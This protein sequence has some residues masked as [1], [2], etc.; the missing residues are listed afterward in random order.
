[1]GTKPILFMRLHPE[2]ASLLKAPCSNTLGLG[3]QC[4]DFGGT[5]TFSGVLKR[6]VEKAIRGREECLLIKQCGSS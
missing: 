6:F 5:Q 3:Y 1:M 2:L 4:M